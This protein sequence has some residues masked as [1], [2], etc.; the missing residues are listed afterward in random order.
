MKALVEGLDKHAHGWLWLAILLT[1]LLAL[2]G[3]LGFQI[4][5]FFVG[6][7]AI[8]VWAADPTGANYLRA[9]WPVFLLLFVLWAWASSFWSPYDGAVFGGNASLLFGLVVALL[10]VPLV[11]LRLS[12]QAKPRLIWAVIGVGVLGVALLFIDSATGLALSLWGDPPNVGQDPEWRRGQAE[13]SVGRGQISYAQLLWPMAALSIVTV[14]R[15]WVLAVLCF[16]G[17]AISAQFNNLSIIIPTLGLAAG[18]AAVAWWKPRIG[19]ILAFS[20]AIASILFAPVLGILSGL[21]DADLLQKIP[22]SWEHRLRMWAYS[23]ELIQQAPLIGNGFDSA[24]VF[25]E[26]TFRAPDG[27]DITVMSMHPHN[28][29]LQIWLETG[30]VG[31]A[32]AVGFLLALIKPVLKSCQNPVRAFATAGL[33]VTIATSGAVTIGVWQH[34]W[35]ALIVFVASMISFLPKKS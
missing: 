12:E 27:R 20:L 16:V 21:V 10:F 2:A 6:L 5:G 34:W 17:L 30:G 8:L 33:I 25:G 32:L 31:V 7:S 28:I 22:L 26:L 29:G 18:F 35:W 14:K 13:M 9:S 19:I 15:G 4:A 24:R 23:W 11:F 1:P 3:G